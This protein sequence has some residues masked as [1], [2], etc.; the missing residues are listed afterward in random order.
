MTPD[1]LD[2]LLDGSA[3]ATRGPKDADL[4]AMIAQ[5]RVEV[6]R[7]RRRRIAIA[8]GALAI[9]LVGGAGVAV[10][11]DGFTW[12]PWAQDPVGAVSFTMPNGFDCELRFAPYTGG[13]DA[14]FVS[15]L[16]RELEDWYRSTDVVAAA[17][18][19]LP[20]MRDHVAALSTESDADPDA[21]MSGLTP[22]ERADEIEHRAWSAEWMAWEWV[23][24]DLE[25][26]ALRDAGYSIPNERLVGTERVSGIQCLDLDGQPYIPG[27]GS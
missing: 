4:A 16:N 7:P 22:A 9:V 18:P 3:P 11:T 10:A 27:A 1:L 25:T 21:D 26:Q 13:S 19:L 8:S 15:E 5:A 23:V 6:P 17:G 20:A 24:S 12:G 2:E 14:G